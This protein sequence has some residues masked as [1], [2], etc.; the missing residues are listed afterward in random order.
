M[1]SPPKGTLMDHDPTKKLTRFRI[2]I[3]KKNC[4]EDRLME[5]SMVLSYRR[6]DKCQVLHHRKMNSFFR[7]GV[8][9]LHSSTEFGLYYMD[10]F[11]RHTT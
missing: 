7:K 4:S 6:L 10:C 2:A 9:H 3:L 11:I 5:F 1:I 8:T